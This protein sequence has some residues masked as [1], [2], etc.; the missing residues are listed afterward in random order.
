MK[1]ARPNWVK[2][3]GGLGEAAWRDMQI[4]ELA[5]VQQD[6]ITSTEIISDLA[7]RHKTMDTDLF[8][9]NL[10]I[11]VLLVQREQMAD[12]YKLYMGA[13]KE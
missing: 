9:V 4:K 8:M 11:L 1:K 3:W 13:V 2:L 6:E 7:A 12:D 10:R 5:E